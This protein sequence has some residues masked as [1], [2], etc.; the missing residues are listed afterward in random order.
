MIF[1]SATDLSS[2]DLA[3]LGNN[4]LPGRR[5]NRRSRIDRDNRRVMAGVNRSLAA[6]NERVDRLHPLPAKPMPMSRALAS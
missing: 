3:L 4:I 6:L 2:S 5:Q 1:V